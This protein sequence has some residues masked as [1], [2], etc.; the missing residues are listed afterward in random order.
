MKISPLLLLLLLASSSVASLKAALEK[1]TGSGKIDS[2]S[3]S[4]QQSGNGEDGDDGEDGGSSGSSGE[5]TTS[6]ASTSGTDSMKVTTTSAE[7]R[8]GGRSEK[9]GVA[10]RGDRVSE[11]AVKSTGDS[12]SEE[13]GEGERGRGLGRSKWAA[14][15]SEML[16]QARERLSEMAASLTRTDGIENA[17]CFGRLVLVPDR[18]ARYVCV[19]FMLP[20]VLV[21]AHAFVNSSSLWLLLCWPRCSVSSLWGFS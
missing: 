4:P 8:V 15:T 19:C 3:T 12:T 20:F 10:V 17:V 21:V 7:I 9:K 5:A 6:T 11:R 14:P 16:L 1:A 2:S 13:T 18:R